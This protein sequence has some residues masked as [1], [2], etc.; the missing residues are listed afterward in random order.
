M[1]RA[2]EP[3]ERETQRTFVSLLEVSGVTPTA[4]PRLNDGYRNS[5]QAAPGRRTHSLPAPSGQ[6]NK[7]ESERSSGRL[8]I[9]ERGKIPRD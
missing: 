2:R 1:T 4:L 9:P 3:Y 6:S 8:T 7:G 5:E